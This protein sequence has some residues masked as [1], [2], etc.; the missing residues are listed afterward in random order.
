[1]GYENIKFPEGSTFLVTGSAGFIG[2]NLVEAILNLGH[3]VRGLDNFS[4]GKKRNVEEFLDNPNYEFIEGDIRDFDTC[5]KACEGID[6][7]LNQAAWG[8]VPR[9]IEM[10]L[11]YE[12]VNIKGTLNMMEAARQ[13]E[14]KKFIYASS[15]SVYGDEPNLPKKEGREGNVFSPYALTKKVNEECGKLYTQLYG[16]D[17]YG[18]RYFNVF[19]R[20]QDPNGAYAA[21]IPKFIKQLLNDEQPTIN[22]D[23]RQSRDF[24]YI[25]NVIEANL[26]VCN[27]SH[28]AAGQAYNIAY[29]G[30]EYLI[31]IYTYLLKALGK[32]TQ[33]IFGP[34][35]KGDIKHSNAD[36]SKAKELL[37]YSPKWS[38]QKGIQAAI[39]WYKENL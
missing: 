34:D 18:L 15:S 28:E 38:F 37:G 31:D 21:V 35:R 6:F 10:P 29:G 2:S 27:A 23:G 9:S 39:K 32:D 4:T 30:R 16:L 14:V 19:G 25:E 17:T 8:S 36:I 24:T 13:N 5:R 12:E 20:R 33:P 1:M 22:G 26:K 11:F 7:V 3:E